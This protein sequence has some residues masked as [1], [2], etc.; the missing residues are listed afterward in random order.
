MC[1]RNWKKTNLGAQSRVIEGGKDE[2]GMKHRWRSSKYRWDQIIIN[3]LIGL[4]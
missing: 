1:L 3:G 2:G 4:G